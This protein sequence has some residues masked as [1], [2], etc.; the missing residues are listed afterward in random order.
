ME[1]STVNARLKELAYLNPG[2]TIW[3]RCLSKEEEESEEAEDEVEGGGSRTSAW[4]KHSHR[5]GLLEYV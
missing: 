4:Q 2:V 1:P 5:G 3:F